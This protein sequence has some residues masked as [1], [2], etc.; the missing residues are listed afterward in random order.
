MG[1]RIEDTTDVA[2][3]A[4]TYIALGRELHKRSDGSLRYFIEMVEMETVTFL[5]RETKR[6]LAEMA[7][8]ERV[9]S[10]SH[11]SGEGTTG[12]AVKS[13]AMPSR[14]SGVSASA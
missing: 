6:R 5:V 2:H 7:E 9:T 14:R 11:R 12:A 4:E 8:A 1:N 13:I 10:I 3:L